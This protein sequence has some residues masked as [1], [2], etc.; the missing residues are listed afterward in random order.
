MRV[1]LT[2]DDLP[3]WR[4]SY[5]PEGYTAGSI[6]RSI[7]SALS[8]NGIPGVYGFSNSW[9]IAKH[10]ELAEVMDRWVESGHYVG[11]H[12]HAHSELP[13]VDALTYCREIDQADYCLAPWLDR[14]PARYFRHPLCYWGETAEKRDVVARH[15]AKRGYRVA[16]ASTWLFEWVWN[17]AWRN[18][19]ERN[20]HATMTWLEHAFVDAAVV[21]LHYDQASLRDWFGREVPGIALGHTLPF[22]AEVAATLFERFIEAG[23][24][25]IQLE[26]AMADPAYREVGSVVSDQFLVFQQK[27]AHA[28]GRP[29][30][31]IAPDISAVHRRVVAMAGDRR[32]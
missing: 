26:E 22:F 31:E 15:L 6:M 18:A 11:N 29:M 5:P 3:L 27:L 7:S 30:R 16:D 32:D 14:S 28:A 20:D 12:T 17:R 4:D 9:A 24:V 1:A 21:Q 23:V 13:D 10:P 2:L 8:A 19:R 25:F